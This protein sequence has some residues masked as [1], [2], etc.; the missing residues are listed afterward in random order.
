MPK[1]VIELQANTQDAVT[2]IQRFAK[3]QKDAFD[4]VKAG[5][6]ALQTPPSRS[7]KLTEGDEGAAGALGEFN[8]AAKGLAKGGMRDLASEVPLV[9]SAL[10]QLASTLQGFP[11]V[12]GG[13][14]GRARGP[15]TW[16]QKL[17]TESDAAL[18]KSRRARRGHGR[19]LQQTQLELAKIAATSAG[20]PGG[21]R[22]GRRQTARRDRRRAGGRDHGGEG[23]ASISWICSGASAPSCRWRRGTRSSRRKRT[24]R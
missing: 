18:A 3:A 24:P 21:D 22:G 23:R 16:R 12:L 13:L 2:Q 4:A 17:G 10:G 8:Q 5:N 15:R 20:D 7:S 14:G 6:P 9:G 11:L 19:R 1:V